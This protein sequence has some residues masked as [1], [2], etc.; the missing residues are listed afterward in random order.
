M[1]RSAEIRL[2]VFLRLR[3]SV[4]LYRTKQMPAKKCVAQ[5]LSCCPKT[6]PGV[7]PAPEAKGRY[8]VGRPASRR[9]RR[10][11]RP[12]RFGKAG[13]RSVPC[14]PEGREAS[15][16]AVIQSARRVCGGMT[17]CGLSGGSDGQLTHRRT[18]KSRG[19]AFSPRRCP[20][21][22]PRNRRLPARWQTGLSAST[23]RGLVGTVFPRPP[24]YNWRASGAL[25]FLWCCR[26]GWVWWL[27]LGKIR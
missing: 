16:R 4:Y 15:S 18:R 12:G 21:I 8:F 2:S 25:N 19:G 20:T 1:S 13:K 11:H 3:L 7:R 6:R 22:S 26:L 9:P 27:P 5:R 24:L 10:N 17:P 23:S 14:K